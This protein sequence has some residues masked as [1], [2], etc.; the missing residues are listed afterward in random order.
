MKKNLLFIILFIGFLQY[1]YT[2][3]SETLVKIITYLR[4]PEKHFDNLDPKIALKQRFNTKDKFKSL[5]RLK[6]THD[7]IR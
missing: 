3:S 5:K 2:S 1:A 6:Q 4:N 7:P